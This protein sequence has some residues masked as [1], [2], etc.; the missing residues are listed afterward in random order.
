[1]LGRA[2]ER[3]TQ[4]TINAPRMTSIYEGTDSPKF[5]EPGPNVQA[6]LSPGSWPSGSLLVQG[7]TWK[8]FQQG[9]GRACQGNQQQAGF[10]SISQVEV[11]RKGSSWGTF[12]SAVREGVRRWYVRTLQCQ[13]RSGRK[14]FHGRTFADPSVRDLGIEMSRNSR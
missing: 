4:A 12:P 10:I 13:I 14:M 5:R 2:P 7:W 3:Q 11:S 1:V 6:L 8:R 9:Q